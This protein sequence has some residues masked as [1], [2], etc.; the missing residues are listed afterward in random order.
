LQNSD[1]SVI[2]FANHFN[3]FPLARDNLIDSS[4]KLATSLGRRDEIPKQELAM[5][6]APSGDMSGW[7]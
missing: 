2:L 5:E 3:G 4:E 7:S 6:I 1:D